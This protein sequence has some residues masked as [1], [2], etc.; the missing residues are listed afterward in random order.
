[1]SAFKQKPNKVKHL[2]TVRTLDE[3]HR[4]K[5]ANF[6]SNFD[7]LEYFSK[8]GD[9]LMTYYDI[10]QGSY[11]NSDVS[12][13]KSDKKN[14]SEQKTEDDLCATIEISQGLKKL[15]E[16][17]QKNRKT[18]KQIKKRRLPNN[19]KN[20]KSI[21]QFMGDDG[22]END[23][24]DEKTDTIQQPIQPTHSINRAT[25]QD[26]YLT[27]IDKN[28]ACTKV[29]SS[30]VIMC[31]Q[32]NIEKILDQSGGCYVCKLCGETE[33]IIMENETSGHKDSTNDKQKYPYKRMNHLK[34]KLNQFQSKETAD[35]PETVY[36]KIFTELKKKRIKPDDASSKD[37]KAILKK[38][39]LTNFY[40]HL[41]QIYCKITNCPPMTLTREIEE[42]II[43]MF[44]TMQE[45]FQTHCPKTRENFLNYSYVLNKLFRIIGLDKYSKYFGLLKSK[46]KLRGQDTIWTK[47]CKDMT[48]PY[49]TSF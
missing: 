9:I 2:T 3:L 19:N 43:S 27:I 39:H 30:K 44:Q 5:M 16:L 21:L 10:V 24:N 49:H 33:C 18:K 40:E 45:S 48:W 47:I 17:S 35:V 32:C 29:R 8:T 25:L 28:Y 31:N 20:Q 26:K 46:E 38:N 7:K 6:S 13:A 22:D 23:E 1:M 36:D 34:E 41:Q 12:E 11:Y 4:E 37:I 15:N 42:A 14:E